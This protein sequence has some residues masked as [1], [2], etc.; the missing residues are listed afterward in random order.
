MIGHGNDQGVFLEGDGLENVHLHQ[1]A[2]SRQSV[3]AFSHRIVLWCVLLG[4]VKIVGG[5]LEEAQVV[6]M[7]V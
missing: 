2:S 4:D 1:R 5:C 3:T 7:G 6:L